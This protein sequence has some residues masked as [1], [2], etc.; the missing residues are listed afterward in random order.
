MW[1]GKEGKAGEE[2]KGRMCFVEWLSAGSDQRQ[3]LSEER[4][5]RVRSQEDVSVGEERVKGRM[6][7]DEWLS[8]ER[9]V[10]RRH[11]IL[12]TTSYTY[13]FPTPDYCE[14]RM[15]FDEGQNVRRVIRPM[16][17]K[18]SEKNNK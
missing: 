8:E 7:F 15:C 2:V 4:G 18:V 10:H 3:S 9:S 1:K 5:A 13:Q 14:K 12:F 16:H 11:I 17:N 6:C